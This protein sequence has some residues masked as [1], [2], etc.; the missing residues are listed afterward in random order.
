MAFSQKVFEIGVSD[1][2][3]FECPATLEG[4]AHTLHFFNKHT[5]PV[6]LTLKFYD[7]S[8]SATLIVV[9]VTIA[10]GEFYIFPKTLDL[11]DGD[12]IIAVSD[13]AASV[14]GAVAVYTNTATPVSGPLTP[15]GAWNSGANYVARDLVSENGSSYIA[16]NPNTNDQP[17]S[18]NWPTV[19]RYI[20]CHGVWLWIS[21]GVQAALR[22][23]HS[24]SSTS[25]FMDEV[26][27]SS[28][29]VSPVCR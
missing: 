9:T 19:L 24:A 14:Q 16:I 15:R 7:H 8:E 1:V 10:A 11:N 6:D 12:K 2:E 3:M 18:A 23:A 28:R 20:S 21:G 22:A 26:F 25:A 17:P 13:V 4:A 29:T 27:R 5:G